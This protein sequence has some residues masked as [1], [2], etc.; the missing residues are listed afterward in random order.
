MYFNFA[1]VGDALVPCTIIS[2]LVPGSIARSNQIT[3]Y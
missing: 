3:W 1:V 2:E